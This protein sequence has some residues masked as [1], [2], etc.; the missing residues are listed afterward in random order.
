M[1]TALRVAITAAVSACVI[2]FCQGRPPAGSSLPTLGYTVGLDLDGGAAA[3]RI[4]MSFRGGPSGTTRLILPS[5]WAGNENLHEGIEGLRALSAAVTRAK[6]PIMAPVESI[7][8]DE[9]MA[10]FVFPRFE[11]SNRALAL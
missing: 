11:L 4:E 6:A 2:L 3:L 9:S 7:M 10:A 8:G 1:R 5:S